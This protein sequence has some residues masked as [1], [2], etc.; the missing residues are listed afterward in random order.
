VVVDDDALIFFSGQY[1]HRRVSFSK[2][3][4]RTCIG[5]SPRTNDGIN[6]NFDATFVL[7]PP[8]FVPAQMVGNARGGV[9]G[10]LVALRCMTRESRQSRRG[11]S[12]C[13]ERFV[14]GEGPL[15]QGPR[16][17]SVS[18]GKTLSPFQTSKLDRD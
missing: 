12:T 11:R 10:T 1:Q 3:R 13:R 4:G 6:V 2:P 5:S 7:A 18:W 14:D 16:E 9:R 15:H 8:V 17:E